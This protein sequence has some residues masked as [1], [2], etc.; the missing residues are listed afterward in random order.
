MAKSLKQLPE[1]LGEIDLVIEARDARL[2]LTSSNV[3]FE[4]AMVEGKGKGRAGNSRER[5]VV[6]TK[7]DLAEQKNEEVRWGKTCNVIILC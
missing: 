6:Y 4:K 7:R 5:L 2:P 3:A 1:L